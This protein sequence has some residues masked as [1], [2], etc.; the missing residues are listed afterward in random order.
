MP[1][2]ILWISSCI[3]WF[4]RYCL[5]LQSFK[6]TS[7]EQLITV[8]SCLNLFGFVVFWSSFQFSKK[9]FEATQI[10]YKECFWICS[11]FG[12]S[13][14]W[15]LRIWICGRGKKSLNSARFSSRF[16]HLRRDHRFRSMRE[17]RNRGSS[18]ILFFIPEFQSR[19][20]VQACL[21]VEQ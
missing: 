20:K 3:Q 11:P 10:N 6:H 1:S 12:R 17:S 21:T 19:S 5:F 2:T 14:M 7:H 18:A 9:G 4:Y 15:D 8:L 13:D 16:E